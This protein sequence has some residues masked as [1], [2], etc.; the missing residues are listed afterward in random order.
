M[1]AAGAAAARRPLV[2][3]AAGIVAA[4]NI[5]KLPPALAALQAEFGLS[6]VQ[7]SWM[8]SLPGRLGCSASARI[9]RRPV[10]PRR[11]SAACADGAGGCRRG[12]AQHRS[13]AARRRASFLL[14]VLRAPAVALSVPDLVARL[15]GAWGAYMP[16]GMAAGCFSRRC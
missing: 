4:L 3:L 11:A 9:A 1:I 16:T 6:L 13:R 15:A 7:V 5:G 8:V 10:D 14:V 12:H 2:L